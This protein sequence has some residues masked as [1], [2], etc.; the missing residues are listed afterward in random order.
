MTF[1]KKIKVRYQKLINTINKHNLLYHSYDS[2]EISDF[3]YDNLYKEL[4]AIE[5]NNHKIITAN[6]PSQRVGSVLLDHFDKI[7]HDIP[8][9]SL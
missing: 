3:E 7:K 5:N 4:K 8:M 6:S 1:E 2:P 9:L